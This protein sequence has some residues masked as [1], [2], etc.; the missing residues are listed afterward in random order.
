MAVGRGP[1]TDGLGLET[2]KVQLDRGYIKVDERMA[3]DEPGLYAIGDVVGPPW[4]AH[5]ASHEGVI[6]VEHIAGVADARADALWTSAQRTPRRS[7]NRQ[8]AT[9]EKEHHAR[10]KGTEHADDRSPSRRVRDHSFQVT[11]V[12][13]ELRPEIGANSR[14]L[15]CP[16]SVWYDSSPR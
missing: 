4:L 9:S 11:G 10:T 6:C 7:L 8:T 13:R 14:S 16:F 5:K 15:R 3:T 12:L 2:T 1:V